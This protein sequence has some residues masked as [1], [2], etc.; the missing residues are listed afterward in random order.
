M[1][2]RH[3]FFALLVTASL[4][5]RLI[6]GDDE[7]PDGAANWSADVLQDHA[8]QDRTTII[9][10]GKSPNELVCDTTLRRMPDGSWVMVMLGGGHTEPLP[11]NR[12]FLA[13]STDAGRTWS[14]LQP[15]DLGIKK[16]NPATALTLSELLVHKGRC[17]MFVATH[18]GTFAD[19]KTW[20]THSDDSGRTWSELTPA[21]GRLHD[22][23]FIR[24]ALVTRDG[25][26][27]L[28]FQ[29]YLKNGK[30]RSISKNR[31]I[32]PPQNP[33]NGVL[34][35]SDDGK[36]WTEH[37]DI[38]ISRDDDYHGW[39]ENNIVELSDGRIVMLIRADNL[40]GV[41]YF[42]ESTDGGRTWPEFAS[43]SSIPN[44][45]SKATLYPLGGD[46]VALLHNPNPKHRSPLALWVSWDGMKT[47]PYQ[48]VLVSESCDGPQGRLNYPDGFVSE[49]R[50][51][52]DFAFDD[53]RHRAVHVRAR[54]PRQD[55]QPHE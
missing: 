36:T 54:L 43:K 47:W 44:P 29:H 34:I 46:T 55:L 24:N 38:R 6:R 30:T 5:P 41:L 32:S 25:R 50:R 28:P 14:K 20:L 39:A 49:D 8:R 12:I 33:R 40:G 35:S 51:W 1:L 2:V 22:R 23:T 9:F 11:Q 19:W 15:I 18:D 31:R 27:L 48:R 42:A 3:L 37:G 26:I 45:G 10:D 7:L 4:T 13:R 21:P 52:L 17:T 16:A 53:N